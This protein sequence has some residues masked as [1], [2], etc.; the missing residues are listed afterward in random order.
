VGSLKVNQ[1]KPGDRV[2]LDQ[3]ESRVR[4]RLLHTAGRE[5]SSSQ[6]CGSTLFCDAASGYIHVEH[7]VTLNASDTINSKTSFERMAS[8]VG[9]LVKE[10]HTDNGIY[11][12]KAFTQEI[13][14][15]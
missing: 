6:F 8:D 1:L 15:N 13:I 4:G 5:P 12:S 7:Q 14:D 3:L 11:T 2:F 9:V 10:Y